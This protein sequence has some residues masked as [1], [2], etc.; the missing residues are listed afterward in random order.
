MDQQRV[1]MGL[2]HSLIVFFGGVCFFCFFPFLSLVVIT[3]THS[4]NFSF[5]Y[6][7]SKN[8]NRVP[9]Y[10]SYL[11]VS[12]HTPHLPCQ[13]HITPHIYIYLL[14]LT[15]QI[16]HHLVSHNIPILTV[17]S[18]PM[19]SPC[20]CQPVTWLRP[21]ATLAHTLLQCYAPG[22]GTRSCD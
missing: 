18:D 19:M 8:G 17:F 15:N 4:C 11:Q 22:A 6:R 21:Q 13:S 7:K 9:P 1:Y 16:H 2:F 12:P 10:T 5:V 20:S 14:S 3:D